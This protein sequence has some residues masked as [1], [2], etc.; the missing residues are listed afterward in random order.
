MLPPVSMTTMKT[1]NPK[2]YTLNLRPKIQ[3]PKPQALN[4]EPYHP[5][6][7][8]QLRANAAPCLSDYL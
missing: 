3:N 6:N 8:A 1:Q 4:T 5:A 7:L 2:P